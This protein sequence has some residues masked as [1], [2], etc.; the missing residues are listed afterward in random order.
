MTT[1]DGPAPDAYWRRPDPSSDGPADDAGPGRGAPPAPAVPPYPGPP[2]GAPPP[3]GWRP[4]LVVNPAPPGALPPQDTAAVDSAERSARTVTYGVG[5]IAA[6]VMII[7]TCLL[8]SR[9]IF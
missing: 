7:L 1:D 2:V 6:A 9:L 8:C 4:P 5:M 3:P